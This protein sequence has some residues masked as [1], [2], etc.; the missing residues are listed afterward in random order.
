MKTAKS[1]WFRGVLAI[2][3]MA[4][5]YLL[6]LTIAGILLYV[7]YAEWTYAGRLH[8]KLAIFCVVSGLIVLWSIVPRIDRFE[9]P[10]PKLTAAKHPKL[11]DEIARI[12]RVT[13]QN[14]P[15]EVYMVGDVNAWVTHR[16]GLMGFGSR[17]VMGVGLPLMQALDVSELRSVLVH[18]F[19]HYA[20]GDTKVGPWVYK[21]RSAI[22]RT[23]QALGDSWIS[24][25]FLWYGRAFL[26]I[27]HAISRQQEFQ[28]DA[29]AARLAGADS[30]KS[31]L[32]KVHG[33]ALSYDA[34]WRNE[35]A[36]VLGQG[37]RPPITDGFRH[38]MS[39]ADIVNAVSTQMQK[40]EQEGAS[41]PYDTHPSLRERLAAIDALD[42][43][44]VSADNETALTLLDDVASLEADWLVFL[45]GTETAGKL[46]PMD[47]ASVGEAVWLPFWQ[48]NLK[49]HL[50]DL[51]SLSLGGLPALAQ[52]PLAGL[53]VLRE[54]QGEAGEEEKIQEARHLLGSAAAVALAKAGWQIRALPGEEVV[55]EKD[56]RRLAPFA[57]V[58]PGDEVQSAGEEWHRV[59]A[60]AGVANLPMS[61]PS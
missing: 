52:Q 50:E 53:K 14:P 6:A 54:R 44:P 12:A 43:S 60:E 26:R 38:F 30:M 4:A 33:A 49:P 1:L 48:E 24:K 51:R 18:E 17:R 41:D 45:A 13:N 7:P 25:P 32:R 56:G 40:E 22:I 58:K 46:R 10:G 31:G 61:P 34:Y 47:W 35:V 2:F 21:T 15:A 11:F 39:A 59:C 55:L 8:I 42:V 5:F 23:V 29:L 37:W 3:L 16:G 28:A 19:G 20:G 36:P 9:A 27:T 57:V